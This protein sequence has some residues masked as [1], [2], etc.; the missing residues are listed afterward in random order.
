MADNTDITENKSDSPAADTSE[1]SPRARNSGEVAVL[2]DAEIDLGKQLN[3]YAPPQLRGYAASCHHVGDIP[4]FA[5]MTDPRYTPRVNAIH[6]YQEVANPNIARLVSYG[7]AKMPG[8]QPNVY[9][10]V[11]EANLGKRLHASDDNLALGWK[12]ERV[13]EKIAIPVIMA[14][15]DLQYRDLVHG[16]IRA[17]NLYDGGKGNYDSIIL[18]DCLSLPASM[19][20]PVVYEPIERAMADPIGR[21][22]GTIE[23]DL[24]S[25]GI[26]LAMYL[27]SYDPLRGKSDNEIISAK[28]MHGSFSAMIGNNDRFSGGVLELLRGLLMD[29]QKQ[30]WTLDEVMSWVDGRRLTPKQALKR[31]KASRALTL[32]G[33]SYY[34]ASTLAHN[35]VNKPQEAVSHIENNEL[36]HWVERSLV[37]EEAHQRLQTAIEAAAE[38]GIGAGYWDRLLPRVSIALDPEAP[39]RYKGMSFLP[40]ALGNAMAE[41]FIQKRGLA[42]FIDLFNNGILYYWVTVS[43]NLNKDISS[44]LNLIDKCRSYL[45]QR[46]IHYGI[47]RCLY[48]CNPVV[49]CLSPLVE[50][51]FVR[52]PE[53]YLMALEDIAKKYKDGEYPG[54]II[55]KHAACFLVAR[56]SRMIEPYSYDLASEE[57]FRHIL[58]TLQVLATIQRFS[59]TDKTPHLSQWISS[60][61][62]PVIDRY[63]SKNTRIQLKKQIDAKK[64]SGDLSE[65]LNIV[66]NTDR[67]REDQHSFRM[68]LKDYF[69]LESEVHQ[70]NIK[71]KNPKFNAERS[72][73]EWAATIAGIVSALLILGF[74]MVH[75]GSE[76]PLQ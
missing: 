67:V 14:L 50:H 2:S 16:N 57:N 15:R 11:Y 55:D 65:I 72:G 37:D 3:D 32:D 6:K 21:G 28:V 70:L 73:R 41:S 75:F 26:L 13:L 46:G 54:R 17:T 71:L 69:L 63:H 33:V 43:A 31:K 53:Q 34:Y 60:L 19:A 4:C 66:E 29:D 5:V 61:L 8:D 9:A 7:V 39:I 38:G 27:R 52:T 22:E 44:F 51:Y 49:H 12:A 74:I 1:A 36:S 62:G 10:L 23:D 18:G 64:G 42:N 30:R 25:L 35:M 59:N 76:T 20:Q 24:Y 68:A 45:K 40:K 47:E 58:G 48:A 56:D